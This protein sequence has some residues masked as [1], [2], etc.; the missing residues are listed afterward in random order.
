MGDG[1]VREGI[2][3]DYLK[4]EELRKEWGNKP[5]SHPHLEPETH[6]GYGYVQEKTGDYVCTV[7]GQDFTKEERDKIIAQRNHK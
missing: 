7:C 2:S 4:A 6:L 3:M 5:C 1:L